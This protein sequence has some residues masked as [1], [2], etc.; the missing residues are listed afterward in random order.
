MS[1][2]YMEDLPNREGYLRFSDTYILDALY[3]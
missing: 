2:I 3:S 1:P